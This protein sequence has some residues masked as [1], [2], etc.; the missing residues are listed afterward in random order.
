[1]IQLPLSRIAVAIARNQS[2][3]L[4]ITKLVHRLRG[5]RDRGGEDWSNRRLDAHAGHV[6][7]IFEGMREAIG[8]VRGK[9][10][11]ELGPGDDIAVAY[12][13]LKAGARRMYTVERFESVVLDDKAVRLLE[14]LDELLPE[15]TAVTA[16]DVVA[17]EGG[18][19]RLDEAK[20]VHRVGLFEACRPPEPVDFA[21]SNDVMEHVESPARI[22]EAAAAALV[23]GGVFVNNVDLAGHN[24]FSSTARPLDFLTCPDWLYDLMFSHIVTSNRVR[25]GD[26]VRDL[27]RAGFSIGETKNILE[28]DP[29]YLEAVRPHMVDR[30]RHLPAEDLK[31]VQVR[32]VA[33]KGRGADAPIGDELATAQRS[34]EQQRNPAS[35]P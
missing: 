35:Y 15:L 19:I 8:D 6:L 2:K 1:M 9:V 34:S 22:F 14:T 30:Y 20:L 26:L 5:G 11:L 23:D 27:R 17:R 29:A 25:Y 33:T 7:E 3:R 32:I 13:F 16:T 21:Y 18:R 4:G 24:V 28:A 10:G 31:V 12:C